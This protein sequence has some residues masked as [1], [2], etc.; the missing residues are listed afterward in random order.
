RQYLSD[1][2]GRRVVNG[3]RPIQT[4]TERQQLAVGALR[5]AAVLRGGDRLGEQLTA[6]PNVPNPR[7]AVLAGRGDGA[8][9]GAEGLAF[10]SAGVPGQCDQRLAGRD[11]PDDGFTVLT[12]GDQPRA[13]GTEG[14]AG[15]LTGM[16]GQR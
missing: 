5:Q 3:R 6:P 7:R 10:S 1:L 16:A 11:V 12:A 4:V 15:Y 14:H 8:A 13:V 9:V 2:P